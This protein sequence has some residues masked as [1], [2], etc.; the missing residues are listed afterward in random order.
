MHRLNKGALP[1]F[2]DY[3]ALFDEDVDC[4]AYCHAANTVIRTELGFRRQSIS[5]P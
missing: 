5:R 2:S 1:L 3:Y 4:S